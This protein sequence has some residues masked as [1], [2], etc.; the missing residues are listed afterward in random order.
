MKNTENTFNVNSIEIGYSLIRNISTSQQ[1]DT[2][3]NV[4]VGIINSDQLLEIPDDENVRR[5][6]GPEERLSGNVQKEIFESFESKRDNFSLLNGGITMVARSLKTHPDKNRLLLIQ[7]SI[8]NGSQTRGVA[9]IYHSNPE[10]PPV[11]I[12]VEIIVTT[13]DDLIADVSISRNYQNKVKD[14]SIFGRRNAFVPINKYLENKKL[15]Y[16]LVEDESDRDGIQPS[17]ALQIAFLLMPKSFW[18]EHMPS[19]QYKK[20]NL[21]SSSNKWIK[22]YAENIYDI[23]EKGEGAEKE[24]AKQALKFIVFAIS[25]GLPLYQELQSSNVWTG[26]RVQNGFTRDSDN[27]IIK[28]ANGWLFPLISIHSKFME[29]DGDNWSFDVPNNFNYNKAISYI[30]EFYDGDVNQLGKNLTL[31]STSEIVSDQF[32]D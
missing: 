13:D 9:K 18:T 28:V 3:I 16:R 30:K 10:N 6:I 12:K 27:N 24:K 5:F 4:F 14:I 22:Q 25:V 8:I 29:Y 20:S 7:P 11:P 31:Y 15:P 17:L 21:Y 23:S 1:K 32:I 19:V 26:V 2:N